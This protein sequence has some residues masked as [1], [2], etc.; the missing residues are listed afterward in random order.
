MRLERDGVLPTTLEVNPSLI[1][2][3]IFDFNAQLQ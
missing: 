2:E 1:H 3:I